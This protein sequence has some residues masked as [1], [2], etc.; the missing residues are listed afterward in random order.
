[1]PG[2]LELTVKFSELAQ[3]LRVP[4]RRQDRVQNGRGSS[5]RS[6]RRRSGARWKTGCAGLSALGGVLSGALDRFADGNRPQHPTLRWFEK[7]AK[8]E[9]TPTRGAGPEG[10]GSADPGGRFIP[11]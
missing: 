2:R 4:G 6:C 9:A 1:V 11:S 10:T 3:P 7:E 8:P 5:L